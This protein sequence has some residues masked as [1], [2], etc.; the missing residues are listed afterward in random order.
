ML[1]KSEPYGS[2]P[3]NRGLFVRV[4]RG[5]YVLN[6]AIEIGRDDGWVG[7]FDLIE[8]PRLFEVLSPAGE[9]RARWPRSRP[10]IAPAALQC[11][12]FAELKMSAS[13]GS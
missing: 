5:L 10:G 1:S 6:P 12:V 4:D 9:S 7:L 3:Y 11:P 2:N 8:L 13:T